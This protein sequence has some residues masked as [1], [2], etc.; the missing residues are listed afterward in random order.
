ML[1]EAL[2]AELQATG[3]S[4]FTSALPSSENSHINDFSMTAGG[5]GSVSFSWSYANRGDYD[6]NNE[7]NIA[8]LSVV[9]Q[10]WQKRDGDPDWDRARVAD[11]DGNGEINAGDIVPIASNYLGSIP[12]W[13]ISGSLTPEDS[14]SWAEIASIGF[15]AGIP[16]GTAQI[17]LFSLVVENAV[18]GMYFA[19]NP[20]GIGAPGELSDVLQF[21]AATTVIA[22]PPTASQGEFEDHIELSWEAQEGALNYWLERS[23]AIDGEYEAVFESSSNLSYNDY[24]I[25]I[26]KHYWYRTLYITEQGYAPYSLAAEG[27]ALEVPEAPQNVKAS[28]G[29]STDNVRITWDTVFSAAGYQV[30]RSTTADGEYQAIGNTTQTEYSDST[31]DYGIAY[32]YS[33]Q[34]TSAAGVSAPSAPDSGYRGVLGQPPVVISVSPLNVLE[35]SFAKFSAVVSGNMPESYLWNFNGAANTSTQ[36]SPTVLLGAP[37]TYYCTLTVANQ[38]GGDAFDFTLNINP[39]NS[40]IDGV[41]PESG[42]EGTEVTFIADYNGAP[43]TSYAWDFGGGASP[44]TSIETSPTVTL[45]TPG[46]YS[47]SVAISS[48]DGTESYFFTLKVIE[49]VPLISEV[50]PLSGDAGEVLNMQASNIGGAV[51]SWAWDFGSAATPSTSSAVSPAITLGA[52][53]NYSCSVTATNAKGSDTFEFTLQVLPPAPQITA[54]NPKTGVSGSALSPMATNSGGQVASWA[55][56]FGG[57]A[58]P[59][60]SA[61]ANPTVTL[62]APGIYNGSLVATNV[63]GSVIFP[64]TLTVNAPP[65][66]ITAVA[67]KSGVSGALIQPIATNS[68]GPVTDWTWNFGGGASP[69]TSND[70]SPQ[71]TLGA[72]GTYNA[73]VTAQTGTEISQLPFTLTVSVAAPEILNVVPASG[74]SGSTVEF[75]P[76]MSGGAVTSWTWDFGGAATPNTSTDP[77]PEVVLGAA[78]NYTMT[79]VATNGGGFDTFSMPLSVAVAIPNLGAVSPTTGVTG[80]GYSPSVSNS[81]GAVD[82]WSWAFTGGATPDSSSLAAPTVTLGSPGAYE[83]SVEGTNVTGS[84]NSAFLLEVACA[85]PTN[86][87]A[88]D[89]TSNSQVSVS[90]TASTGAD[91]YIVERSTSQNGSYTELASNV[92]T[93]S[94]NDTGASIGITYWY[95]IKAVVDPEDHDPIVSAPG[96]ANSGWRSSA[97][98]TG[99]AATDGDHASKVAVSWSGVTGATGYTVL[100]ATSQNGSYSSVGTPTGTSFDDTTATAGTTYWYKVRSETAAGNGG[101]SSADDGYRATAAPGSV[102]ATDGAHSDKVA[103]SWNSVTGATGYTVLRATSQNGSYSSIGTPTGTSFDDTTASIGTTYWYK[104]RSESAAGSGLTGGPDSGWRSTG[105]AQNVSAT[106]GDFTNKVR[107]TWDSVSG[108]TSYTILRADSENGSY[109]VLGTSNNEQYDDSTVTVDQIYWYKVR[110]ESAPGAGGTSSADDG[111]ATAP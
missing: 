4:R 23:E 104:V 75:I 45:G 25:D 39:Q 70:Q 33:V 83:C 59:N 108:A 82:T 107:I 77:S 21:T 79:L 9:G 51:D 49:G 52:S 16:S 87:Q 71:I 96:T 64:F 24:S 72:P 95:R 38:W 67:P 22:P 102:A 66:D 97:A 43:A 63:N 53:G 105:I 27:W 65:P 111:F 47:A 86:I 68:G 36:S 28:D 7:V 18:N 106:D 94:Y 35:G 26:S 101:T 109:S 11:G 17:P 62:G 78:G 34:A 40:A 100:R 19:V 14:A 46:D 90:W 57:G 60:S 13:V 84:S 81:G 6:M 5:D 48:E 31:G 69:N 41:N 56:Y 1:R 76:T 54:V 12:A 93:T 61:L 32:F 3:L 8:D 91:R 29:S 92:T 55:W 85:A 44:D 99:V 37:G 2:A 50:L 103:I 20:Q 80:A 30:S 42:V 74:S 110:S 89:G 98:P 15:D 10:Y 58:T 73:T 88:S